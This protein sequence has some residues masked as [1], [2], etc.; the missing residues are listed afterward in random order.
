MSTNQIEMRNTRGLSL[1]LEQ[2]TV[3]NIEDSLSVNAVLNAAFVQ[4]T[5]VPDEGYGWTAVFGCAEIT[6]WF[7]GTTYSWGVVQ[8]ALVEEGVSGAPTL[9]FVG[10]LT[11]SCIAIL[12]V[13]NA[14]IV[15]GIG[16]Q[17]LAFLGV[18]LLGGGEILAASGCSP[19]WGMCFMTESI[20]PAQY[21]QRKRGLAN[22]IV[23]A[24]GGLGG[25]AISLAIER[26]LA[27]L[28][29]AWAL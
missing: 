27:V 21:F 18:T 7:V 24:A 15:S 28:G 4:E 8:T 6:W 26:L 3:D 5:T 13:A 16:A 10:S 20:I 14:R 17:K 11:V 2:T 29:P 23:F 19:Q 12:A 22:G 9:R 25:A 1:P